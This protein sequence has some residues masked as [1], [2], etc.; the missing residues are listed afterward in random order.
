MIKFFS[1]RPVRV[2]FT[3]AALRPKGGVSTFLTKKCD[4][5]IVT[6]DEA[7]HHAPFCSQVIPHGV[8]V[9]PDP[10]LIPPRSLTLKIAIIGRVRYEKGTDVFVHALLENADL[11]FDAYIVGETTPSHE[12]FRNTLQKTISDK[13][14]NENFHW[15]DPIPYEKMGN[16]LQGMDIV[17]ACPRY[18]GFGL[19]L[20]EA[21]SHGCAIIG[22]ETGAFPTLIGDQERGKLV[23]CGDIKKLSQALRA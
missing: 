11:P 20:F 15:I 8:K 3:W 7:I 5:I 16:F 1:I 18:E 22:T 23:P 12:S 9:S 4:R 19:T 2:V 21:A 17:V 14:I 6:S 10:I 13:G